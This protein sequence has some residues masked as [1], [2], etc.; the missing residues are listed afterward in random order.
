[1]KWAVD[2]RV[3]LVFGQAEDA[4]PDDAV[5]TDGD[6]PA[7]NAA[8][9]LRLAAAQARPFASPAH[10]AGCACCVS[11]QPVAAALGGLFLARARGE[12]PFFRRVVAVV[13]DAAAVRAAVTADPL[14]S[15]RFR[16]G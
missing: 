6:A 14:V 1:M 11:R 5:L 13:A 2:A 7:P 15:G 3:A 10:M 9:V 12:V 16:L 4:G 8:T